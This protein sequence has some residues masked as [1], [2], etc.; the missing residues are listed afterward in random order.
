MKIKWHL[1]TDLI[2]CQ[3]WFFLWQPH[4]LSSCLTFWHLPHSEC[5]Y[6]IFSI[7][8]MY[9]VNIFIVIAWKVATHFIHAYSLC[10]WNHMYERMCKICLVDICAIL[11][12]SHYNALLSP[13]FK[14]ILVTSSP[15]MVA[16]LKICSHENFKQ[17]HF[18]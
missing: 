12:A 2:I 16:I 10:V 14:V 5:I 6:W 15:Y 7:Q 8:W 4:S 11:S 13:T 17:L 18:L 9:F 3:P 1:K